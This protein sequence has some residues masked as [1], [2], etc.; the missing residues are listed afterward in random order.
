MLGG[1]GKFL[2][3]SKY[4]ENLQFFAEAVLALNLFPDPENQ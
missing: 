4:E 1:G 3:C 2:G